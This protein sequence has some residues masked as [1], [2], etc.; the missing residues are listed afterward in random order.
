MAKYRECK[1]SPP[2][3]GDTNYNFNKG[4]SGFMNMNKLP[5]MMSSPRGSSLIGNQKVILLFK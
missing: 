3:I 5:K 2:K 1:T 4:A